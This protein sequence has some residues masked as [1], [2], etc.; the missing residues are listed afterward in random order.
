MYIIGKTGM[1]KSTLL[2]TFITQD[3]I[4][5]EGLALLDPHG[6]LVDQILSRIPDHRKNQVI[7]F[8][9]PD[10][11]NVLGFNPLEHIP[12]EQRSM[13]AGGLLKALQKIWSDSWGHRMEHILRNT[14]YALLDYPNA[15]FAEIP[16]LFFDS[17][18]R[19][20]VIAH[21]L[22]ESVKHF[23][24]REFEDIP[25]RN[26]IEYISPVLNKVEA[27]LTDPLLRTILTQPKSSF[28]LR[29][30]MD[31]GKILLVNLAK[32]KIGE[33][34]SNLLGALLLSK[35][36]IAALS[37]AEIPE[38][39]RKDFYLYLDE[40]QNFSTESF[41]NMLSELR[42]YGVNLILAHQYISQL[43][44]SIRDAIVGNVGTVISFQIGP[45]DAG[46][47][48]NLFQPELQ[49]IDLMKLPRFNIYLSLVID[50]KVSSPFSATTLK[51]A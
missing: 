25:H 49:P 44:R 36:E 26:R 31:E 2:E 47:M 9:V 51:I 35:I 30:I 29:K 41:V 14:L 24:A 37:R 34:S 42:K 50:G 15:T 22:N 7:Y 23:W 46:L 39:H 1:G 43:D 38:E 5:G 16:R 27:F 6:E 19:K 48:A 11:T 3:L 28:D 32:G 18:F 33:D 45:D 4:N 40:F 17:D 13:M 8:N 12:V 10:T 21:T 20:K